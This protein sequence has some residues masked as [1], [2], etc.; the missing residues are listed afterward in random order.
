MWQLSQALEAVQGAREALSQTHGLI[1]DMAQA[2]KALEALRE[3]AVQHKQLQ[4]L[5]QLLPRLQAGEF[6][7][8][9][10]LAFNSQS[11]NIHH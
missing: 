10:A 6:A 1:Q 4:A 5:S 8:S 11:L 3:Q 9:W 7:E 2:S